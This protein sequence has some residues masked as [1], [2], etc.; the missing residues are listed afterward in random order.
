MIAGA[1]WA[2]SQACQASLSTVCAWWWTL[3]S[4]SASAVLKMIFCVVNYCGVWLCNLVASRCY[5]E[6]WSHCIGCVRRWWFCLA[7][8]VTCSWPQ[9]TRRFSVSGLAREPLCWI[10]L[11]VEF[12]CWAA[13]ALQCCCVPQMTHLTDAVCDGSAVMKYSEGMCWTLWA[14]FVAWH[15]FVKVRSTPCASSLIIVICFEARCANEVTVA[16]DCEYIPGQ[17]NTVRTASRGC[18]SWGMCWA[19]SAL[20]R[21]KHRLLCVYWARFALCTV[22]SCPI[23][24]DTETRICIVW[25]LQSCICKLFTLNT[26]IVARDSVETVR[27]LRARTLPRLCIRKLLC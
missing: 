24:S 21:A 13:V 26:N 11:I 15:S 12:P 25:D 8:C 6:I 4:R 9:L 19:F 27:A 16:I 20:L 5:A 1:K 10:T 23:A 18:R 7:I 22:Q 14:L 17:T 2:S 3:N